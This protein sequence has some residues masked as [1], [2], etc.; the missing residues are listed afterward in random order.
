ML[1]VV[2]WQKRIVNPWEKNSSSTCARQ[3]RVR[4]VKKQ[5]K[6]K[7]EQHYRKVLLNG[8]TLGFDPQIQNNLNHLVEH[9][10]QHHKK[11]LAAK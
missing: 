1:G 11:I 5:K 4:M 10:K 3:P 6:L 2:A 9:N 7:N 8:H